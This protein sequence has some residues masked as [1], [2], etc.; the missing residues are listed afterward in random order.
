MIMGR[1]KLLKTGDQIAKSNLLFY[2]YHEP[3]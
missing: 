3:Q 1:K 2:Q